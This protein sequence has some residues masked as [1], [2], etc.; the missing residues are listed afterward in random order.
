VQLAQRLGLGCEIRRHLALLSVRSV[1]GD[2]M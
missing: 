1:R 2:H